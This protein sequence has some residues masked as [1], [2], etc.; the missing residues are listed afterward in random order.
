MRLYEVPMI[1]APR[2]LVWSDVTDYASLNDLIYTATERSTCCIFE[3]RGKS[4]F[5]VLALGDA[6]AIPISARD[7]A[8]AFLRA[9]LRAVP[10]SVTTAP[11]SF[12]GGL[13]AVVN[14]EALLG[15]HDARKRGLAKPSGWIVD[16]ER[17]LIADH[18]SGRLYAVALIRDGEEETAALSALSA[19]ITA[20][21]NDS[22]SYQRGRSSDQENS[23]QPRVGAPPSSGYE[24]SV[25]QAQRLMSVK[26]VDE[27]V[28]SLQMFIE[29]IG[30]RQFG[31]LY[32]QMRSARPAPY[33]AFF[34]SP[35]LRLAVNSTLGCAEIR[36]HHLRAETDAG[37]RKV[38]LQAPEAALVWDISSKER[39]EHNYALEALYRD[40]GMI[41]IPE[42]VKVLTSVEPRQFGNIAHLFAEMEGTLR[43]ELDAVDAIA[44]LSP[45]GAVSGMPKDRA[46]NIVPLIEREARG[47][48]G[49]L[50]GVFGFDGFAS[51]ATI[52]R[53][54]WQEDEG[55]ARAR[56]GASITLGSEPAQEYRE[57]M[58]KAEALLACLTGIG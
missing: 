57:C 2:K 45:H 41:A 24:E 58:A 49:G 22:A 27:V 56:F 5:S 48:Y 8:L 31:R 17:Y 23:G 9:R 47:P 21:L 13:W 50:V 46:I 7:D 36:S 44:Q 32:R 53:S 14:Y 39:D 42:S 29:G 26:G 6:P 38:D 51:V 1:S 52:I 43:S 10:A 11:F 33:M 40:M 12:H 16:L 34:A 28:V 4:G 3:C 37:T 55:T 20:L 35:E 19:D 18:K 54:I 25:T 30:G 15:S